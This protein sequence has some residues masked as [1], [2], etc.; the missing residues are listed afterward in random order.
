MNSEIWVAILALIGTMFG[1]LM[2]KISM[3]KL[4]NYRIGILENKV[5]KLSGLLERMRIAEMKINNIFDY[6]RD[7]CE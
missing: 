5:D 1:S 6:V 2:G 7:N 4:L 3:S